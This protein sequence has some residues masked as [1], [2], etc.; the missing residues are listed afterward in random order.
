M[1]GNVQ[2]LID[3]SSWFVAFVRAAILDTPV[4]EL[5]PDELDWDALYVLSKRQKMAA[6][7][8][9][10][11]CVSNSKVPS[12]LREQW[13]LQAQY[14]VSREVRFDYEYDLIVQEF[15]R[16]EI[17][18]VPLKGKMI[19][20]FWPGKGLRE[21]SD[22]DILVHGEDQKRAGEIM[23]NLGY[24]ADHLGGMHDVYK[25]APIYNVELHERLFESF[26]EFGHQF[27]NVWERVVPSQDGTS[28]YQM[29]PVDF[30]LHFLLHFLKHCLNSGAGLR[31]FVDLFLIRKSSFLNNEILNSV[32]SIIKELN[33]WDDLCMI[34]QITDDL[35][36]NNCPISQ[37]YCEYIFS[38]GTYGGTDWRVHNGIVKEGK[39]KYIVKRI[40]MPYSF[41]CKKY[42]IL[43]YLPFLL[44]FAWIYR[45]I[46]H[47]FSGNHRKNIASEIRGVRKSN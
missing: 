27:D 10:G 1:E 14:A 12:D 22:I 7:T 26:I 34:Y 4:Q 5:I 41:M 16:A 33:L 32:H 3:I 42:R 47:L 6:L 20:S 13:E 18:Y 25:K 19:R 8:W 36:V 30:Y 24:T 28:A 23:L 21:F 31:F 39:F 37:Q 29:T 45:W 43:Q 2:R 9:K 40:F 35:F 38:G 44:P 46:H 15:N 11:I 17:P